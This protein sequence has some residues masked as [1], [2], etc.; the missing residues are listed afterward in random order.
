MDSLLED[1]GEYDWIIDDPTI[2]FDALLRQ[3]DTLVMGR[4]T[5]ATMQAAG[6]TPAG[7]GMQGFVV[8][9]TLRPEDCPGVTVVSGDVTRTIRDLKGQAGK[10]IWLYGGGVLFRSLLDAGLVDTVE[11][12]VIPVLLGS[13]IPVVPE[14]RRCSLRLTESTA[15]ASGIVMTKYAVEPG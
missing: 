8:S 7:M 1:K 13:G 2:D 3:F 12:A 6:L 9:T 11:V 14:G 5:Y 15:R 4:G 10:D